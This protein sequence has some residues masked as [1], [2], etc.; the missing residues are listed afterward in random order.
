M[1]ANKR[2]NS[3]IIAGLGGQGV[4][5]LAEIIGY[6]LLSLN[7]DVKFSSIKG[8]AQR[9][10][11]TVVELR[12]GDKIHSP[13]ISAGEADFLI[14]FEKF[15]AL[16]YINQLKKHGT[17]LIYDKFIHN[18]ALEDYGIDKAE[19]LLKKYSNQFN[20]KIIKNKNVDEKT[21]NIIMLKEFAK[22]AGIKN[23]TLIDSITINMPKH[24][25]FE[26]INLLK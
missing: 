10:G 11:E 13:K 14:A 3:V 7:Y 25:A 23:E 26:S 6:A 12:F 9:D 22:L 2:V 18:P 20:I 8:M 4:N 17:A 1:E 21:I 15:E 5:K 19:Q 16:R 24:H